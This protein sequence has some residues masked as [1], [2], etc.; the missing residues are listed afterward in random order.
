MYVLARTKMCSICK[1]SLRV[2]VVKQSKS[3]QEKKKH[4][5]QDILDHESE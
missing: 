4:V 3:L 1:I 5:I 2:A